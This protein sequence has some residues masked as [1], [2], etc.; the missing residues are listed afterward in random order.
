MF[1][2]TRKYLLQVGNFSFEIESDVSSIHHYLTKH[3]QHNLRQNDGRQFVDYYVSIRHGHWL[4]R[5]FKPQ[6]EFFFNHLKPFKPL[7]LSQAHAFLEWGMNWILST[8]AHQYLIIHAASLEK[9]GKGV[10]ISAPSG[11]GKSTLCA[12]LVS[13]GWRLMSD[14]LALIDTETLSMHGLARPINLK[15]QSI[16][17][18][19]PHYNNDSFSKVAIDTHKGTVCLLKPPRSSIEQAQQPVK[20]S[21]L[22]FVN[23]NE[24]ET[25][26]MEHVDKPIALTEIIKNSFNFGMLNLKGFQCAKK[27]VQSCDAIYVEYSD[28]KAC[29]LALTNY[30][31]EDISCDK[32]C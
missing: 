6:V 19:K 17:V 2:K 16:D 3:Y 7:P 1:L 23:Y 29:N 5:L 12:Y 4:R 32:T 25:I 26:F 22:V 21:L 9:N 30:L 10:I 27:L 14:E 11:S 31:E 8:Q 18:I 28:L 15:N 20:P 13:Q 24:D